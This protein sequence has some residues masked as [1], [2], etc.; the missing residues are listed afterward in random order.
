LILTAW[1]RVVNPWTQLTACHSKRVATR[2]RLTALPP[3]GPRQAAARKPSSDGTGHRE[4]SL[5]PPCQ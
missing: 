1:S 5:K 3:T 2:W 4:S